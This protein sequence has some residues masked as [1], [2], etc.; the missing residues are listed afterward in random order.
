M[1][2]TAPLLAALAGAV[3]IALAA[4]WVVP[5]RT[6]MGDFL[7]AGTTAAARLLLGE[8]DAGPAS[9]LVLIGIEGAPP[10]TLARLSRALAGGLGRSG[11]FGL[12]ANG[13]GGLPAADRRF[14]FRHRYLLS[15]A[16]SAGAFAVP[17]LADDLRLVR[18]GLLSSASPLVARYGLADPVGAFPALLGAWAGVS[19]MR[20]LDGVWFAPH[21]DR[22]LLVARSRARVLDPAAGARAIAVIR[23]GFD[24]ARPGAARVLLAGPAV[25]GAE[26]AAVVRAD[27]ERLSAFSTM[28]VLAFL[29]WRFR[30][31]SVV[32]AIAVPVLLSV[33]AA[34]VVVDLIFG[35]VQGIA[36]GFGMTMLGVSV[37]YP[38]LLIGHRKRGEAAAGTLRRIGSALALSVAAAS[39][40][41]I[42]MVFSGFPWLA[43]LGLFALTGL[44]AAYSATRLLL[45]RL[46]VA[47]DLAPVA[48]GDP[49]MFRRAESLRRF[50]LWAL[51]P[52]ALAALFLI[53]HPPRWENDL[54]RLSPVPAAARM[55]DAEL[56]AELGAADAG[57]VG[58]VRGA[59]PEIVLQREEALAPV[60]AGLARHHVIEAAEF[61][62]RILPSLAT[63]AA[64]AA[65][66]PDAGTLGARLARA[67]RGLAFRA[68]AFA[69]FL[70]AVAASRHLAPVTPAA[71]PGPLLRARL[72]ALLFFRDGAWN[73]PILFTGLAAP[74]ALAAAL[75]G[76]AGVSVLDIPRTLDA[77][78]A[79]YTRRA[80]GLLAIGAAASLVLLALGLRDWRRLAR[81]AG[82]IAAALLLTVA[83]LD[84][85]G[86]RLSL[87]HLISLQLVV[88]I[89]LDYAL[90]FSR[91]RLDVEERVRTLR[92]LITCNGMTL[93]SFGALALAQTPLLREIG[94]TTML[95]ALAA[96]VF[97]FLFA[98]IAHPETI[99]E[100]G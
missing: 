36:L 5:L 56:R 22:A 26:A 82:A 99:R 95:G 20:M 41:L 13:A 87:L 79:F 72:A 11:L 62:A 74:R 93:L 94:V 81:V 90:F 45:P 33:A 39:L 25:L 69:P 16:V 71:L 58:L 85:A 73:G 70:A 46:I 7:P 24:A 37:D 64:R 38:V 27:V 14:L 47:A 51:A 50:R 18:R 8:I 40:G 17:A 1:T 76:R 65:L 34:V 88:G 83:V 28:V 75:G 2:R 23:A 19:R 49:A 29:F 30:S 89:G 100:S 12:V 68:G 53:V 61:A 98:G 97:A 78:A 86:A 63:Q 96:M 55:V 59:S 9:R 6:D 80:G 52:L 4:L 42:G 66:L 31:I 77:L 35:F 60:L 92:T 67:G 15:P 32:A 57:V 3:L 54:A 43:E 10:A 44:G 48:A 21:R 91:P 84:A